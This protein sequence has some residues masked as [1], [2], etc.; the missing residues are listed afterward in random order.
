M[1]IV[2]SG[3][4][5]VKEKVFEIAKKLEEKRIWSNNTKR[6]YHSYGKKRTFNKTLWWNM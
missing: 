6:I 3:S 5:K 1:R 2:L 4:S